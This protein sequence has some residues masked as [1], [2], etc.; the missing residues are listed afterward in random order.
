MSRLAKPQAATRVIAPELN[1]L[2]QP[3]HH[4]GEDLPMTFSKML[5]G[6]VAL[7]AVGL[8]GLGSRPAF[9]NPPKAA[10]SQS[11]RPQT[12]PQQAAAV[13]IGMAQTMFVD[14]PQPLVDILT[15]PFAGLMKEFTGLDG[16][17][18]VGG[19]AFTLAQKLKD[20]KVH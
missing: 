15:Y 10:N 5:A 16:K 2:P 1:G 14:V 7:V 19:D 17:L 8:A 3:P 9:A 6:I 12:A 4:S 18:S 11:A 20:N 13:E